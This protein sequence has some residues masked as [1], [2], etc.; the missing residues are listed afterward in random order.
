MNQKPKMPIIK[1][2]CGVMVSCL[3]STQRAF[4]LA[5]RGVIWARVKK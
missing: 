2:R 1:V 4:L 5:E 3:V